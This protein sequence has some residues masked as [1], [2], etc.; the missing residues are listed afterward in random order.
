MPAKDVLG[1]ILGST[2]ARVAMLKGVELPAPP[3]P[4]RNLAD[5]ILS[6]KEAG[7]RAIIS[8]IKFASPS[9]GRIS[10]PS[11]VN[12]LAGEMASV[13]ACGISVLTEPSFF[14]GD[15]NY[16]K[17]ITAPV[18]L[19]RKDF[20]IDELQIAESRAYGADSI[21]LISRILG[22]DLARF[23]RSSRAAGMEPL[24]EVHT[25]EDLA[26]ALVSGASIIGINNRD[27]GTLEIDLD[28]TRKLSKLIPDEKIVVSE[29]GIGT[30]KDLLSLEKYADAFLIG[31]SIMRSTDVGAKIRC[32]LAPG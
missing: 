10:H 29:S 17:G 3:R 16:L 27:L 7:L 21:L 2:R 24:V 30:E 19:L 1:Q 13:G 14:S 26:L 9:K 22:K 25:K 15:V 31:T 18:P 5:A 4:A 12:R 8:E 23:I 20:I 28:T 32:L 11:D 6:K